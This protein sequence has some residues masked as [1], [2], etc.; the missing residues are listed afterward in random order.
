MNGAMNMVA[1]RSRSSSTVRAER[2]AGT[3]HA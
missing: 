3:A 1:I 2:I